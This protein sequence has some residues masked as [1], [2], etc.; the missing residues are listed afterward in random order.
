MTNTSATKK[1]TPKSKKPVKKMK[2]STEREKALSAFQHGRRLQ[3]V[4]ALGYG[5]CFTCGKIIHISE[6][7][8]GHGIPRNHKATELEPTNCHL[9]CRV[10]NRF[11]YGE[12]HLFMKHVASLYGEEEVQRLYDLDSASK[13]SE[14]ALSRLSEEDRNL[15]LMPRTATYYHEQFLKW[16]KVCK[17]LEHKERG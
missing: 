2:I 1:K 6:G 5:R 7:D 10:C 11:N 12:Q 14:E 15:A 16:N 4:N 13:G 3:E 8:G 9:Q 17:D